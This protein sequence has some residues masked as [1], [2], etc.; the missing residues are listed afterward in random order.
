MSRLESSRNAVKYWWLLLLLGIAVFVVGIFIFTYPGLSYIAM[1]M[2]FGI[3][4]LVSGI[5]NIALAASS[6]NIAVGRGWLWAGG[7]IE[8]IVGLI[9]MLHP[10]MSAT[11]LPL[12]L[13]FW[14]IFRS[15]G[16]IGSGSDMMSLKVPG[17]GWT[18]FVGI[19]L[20][21]CSVMILAQ[22]LLF[23]VEAVVIWVGVSF[24]MAGISLGVFSFQ[25]RGLHKH[26]EK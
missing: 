8:V 25:L 17:S 6:C 7:I 22:P 11:T 20:L 23:G 18:I 19:L 15:F 10:V 24:L 26:F 21:F 12:F 5:V 16:L 1:S 2:L 4:I 14:L 3:L 9:L 13:G